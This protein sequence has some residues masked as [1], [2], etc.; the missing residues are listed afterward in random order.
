[1]ASKTFVR[2]NLTRLLAYYEN[3]AATIR[4]TIGFLE[5]AEPPRRGRLP[6]NGASNGLSTVAQAAIVEE[7]IRRKRKRD[8][9]RQLHAERKTGKP[10]RRLKPH[11]KPHHGYGAQV[12]KR[13][14]ISARLLAQFDRNDPRIP[15]ELKIPTNKIGALIRRG[16]L[17]QKGGG[18]I[19]SAKPYHVNVKDAP[20]E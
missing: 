16:Y 15:A 3:A 8:Y 14:E 12:L 6:S 13:R 7:E 2:D 18:Y 9:Q 4:A 10:P 1:M 19:R 20:T 5:Q 11:K 17:V